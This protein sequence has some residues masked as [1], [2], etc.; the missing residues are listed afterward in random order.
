VINPDAH[1]YVLH[2]DAAMLLAQRLLT[3]ARYLPAMTAEHELLD[4]IGHGLAQ[5]KEADS[6]LSYG[7]ATHHFRRK[8]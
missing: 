4:V 2:I 5:R 6:D 1:I 7:A 3:R 8:S